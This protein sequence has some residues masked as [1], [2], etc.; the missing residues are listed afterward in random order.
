MSHPDDYPRVLV[1][2]LGKIN[3]NDTYNNGLLLR[4]LFG[5]DWPRDRLAQIY[6]S[7]DSGDRGYFG[8]YYKLGPNDRLLGSF[9]YRLRSDGSSG[10][11]EKSTLMQWCPSFPGKWHI[12]LKSLAKRFIVDTGLYE[13][14]F[15]PRL[16]EELLAWVDDFRPDVI[17]AQGYNLTFTLLPLLI[18]RATGARLAVLTTDDWPKYQ[19][20]GMHGEPSFL[21]WLVRPT[22]N[23]ASRRLFVE[24]DIPIAF[25]VSMAEEYKK[26]YGKFFIPV[27]HADDPLR[28]DSSRPKYLNDSTTMTI[29][30]TGTFNE[31]RWP[32][33]LDANEAC[34]ELNR[35]GLCVRLAVLSS[36][37][38]V[39]GRRS[40]STAQY[41]D[42]YP[43][44]GN[45][46][47]PSYLKGAN[48]LL[49][50]E[51][52]DSKFVSAIELSISSK[53]HLFMFS[54]R[55]I[56]VYAAAEAG[57]TKY[58][59]SYGWARVV[60]HRSISD[61]SF[62][63]QQVLLNQDMAMG[64]IAKADAVASRHHTHEVNQARLF[65]A[66]RQGL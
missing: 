15:R 44:P 17:F 46:E 5:R 12:G 59:A 48:A 45:D 4:N 26:R 11:S 37:I 6:S 33:L 47:L 21:R 19:Y 36:A 43:D 41:V 55:P 9:F 60:S 64:L 42:I 50:L 28:F 2:T 3:D 39:D 58:A 18:K 20:T 27:F 38:T 25:G 63:L 57:V 52:F 56:V 34:A 49:L 23:I 32:L 24:S 29:V 30:V 35:Q 51:G 61:L 22:V 7:G 8:R 16:S 14:I 62:A 40:L 1:V 10:K 66:L 65:S 31:F 13:I 53:A 54:R